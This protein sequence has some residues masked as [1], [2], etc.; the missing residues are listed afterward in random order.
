MGPSRAVLICYRS[1]GL[2]RCGVDPA[3]CYHVGLGTGETAGAAHCGAR[4]ALDTTTMCGWGLGQEL[5]ITEL[6]GAGPAC[7]CHLY[8]GARVGAAL[9]GARW[10]W[11]HPLPPCTAG[12]GREHYSAGVGLAPHTAGDS[13]GSVGSCMLCIHCHHM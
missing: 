4:L 5:H 9:Y 7:Y 8:Q 2:A 6:G 12:D 13:S 11:P 1:T 3:W 10:S